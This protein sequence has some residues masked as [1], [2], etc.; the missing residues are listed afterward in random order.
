MAGRILLL[1]L[2]GIAS[3][4]HRWLM[5]IGG[6]IGRLHVVF[7]SRAYRVTETNLEICYPE[8]SKTD[9]SALT[10]AS[11]TATGQT[12]METPAAWL[13]NPVRIDRWIT[14]IEG[15]ELLQDA[16]DDERG[17]LLLLPHLGNW[18]LANVYFANRLP[19]TGLYQP[20]KR[21]ALRPVMEKVRRNLGNELVPTTRSGLAT[22]YRRLLE[23]KVV[24][25]LPDQVPSTGEFAPFFGHEALTDRLVM[26]LI[27]KSR[28]QVLSVSMV[29][30]HDGGFTMHFLSA[31][32]AVFDA[33]SRAALAG[34][35]RSIE[36]CVQLAP[37]QYQWEYKRFKERPSG[38]FRLYNYKGESSTYH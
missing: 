26:R 11:L 9:R 27:R 28:P 20:P 36:Q 17:L 5:V 29:R 32:E 35:N 7:R 38:E 19:S 6:L 30:G 22:L 37:A 24:V 12:L 18:G 3:L 33:N 1:F 34:V 15:E 14:R 25:V 4:P 2:R 13:G 16:L 21:P 10:R 8:M 31:D 23:G